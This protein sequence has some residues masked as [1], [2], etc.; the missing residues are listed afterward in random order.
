VRGYIHGVFDS[1]TCINSN[2]SYP[3]GRG[4]DAWTYDVMTIGSGDGWYIEDNTFSFSGVG[5]ICGAGND[6]GGFVVRYNTMT[7]TA[8]IYVEMHSN[9]L[10]YIKG[11]QIL[12]AYGNYLPAT[13]NQ[14]WD[15]RGGKVRIFYNLD[16]DDSHNVREEFQDSASGDLPPNQCTSDAPQV[17]G[18]AC[19]CWKVHQSY[20]WNNRNISTNDIQRFML[21]DEDTTPYD[22]YDNVNLNDP[23][24]LL[25]NREFFTQRNTGTFDGSGD[26]DKGGGVGCGTYAQMIAITPT[27]TNCGFWVTDQSCTDLTDYTG[28][29]PTTPISG[30]LYRWSGVEWEEYYSPYTYPH[31]LRESDEPEGGGPPGPARRKDEAETSDVMVSL[32]FYNMVLKMIESRAISIGGLAL[33][34]PIIYLLRRRK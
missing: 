10:G 21:M 7:G 2:G 28:A 30:T 11:S 15:I 29:N 16:N 20:M 19:T 24:E 31:P 22:R 9:Q 17:C 13:A 32:S 33:L 8:E 18:D 27:L 25:E 6:G 23:R 34:I 1:N 3:Q 26:T 14:G 4:L 5:D 12:E